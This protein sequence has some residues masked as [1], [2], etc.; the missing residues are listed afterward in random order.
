VARRF[1]AHST[2]ATWLRRAAGA[3]FVALGARLGLA[4]RG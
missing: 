4:D 2:V 3:S 1:S